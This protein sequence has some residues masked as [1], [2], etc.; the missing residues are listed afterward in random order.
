[1]HAQGGRPEE[2]VVALGVLQDVLHAADDERVEAV[3]EPGAVEGAPHRLPELGLVPPDVDVREDVDGG[4]E[5][6]V[7]VGE[8]AGREHDL[9]AHEDPGDEGVEGDVVEE[10]A[11]GEEEARGDVGREAGGVG[12]GEE[13]RGGKG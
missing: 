6:V 12:A 3:V 9:L 10:G 5:D 8:G 11:L 4:G 13:V 2:L 1:M 7:A